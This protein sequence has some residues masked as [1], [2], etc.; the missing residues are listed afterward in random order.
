MAEN[1]K[2]SHFRNGDRIPEAR[3]SEEWVRSA[4]GGKPAWCIIQNDPENGKKYG[5]LYNW[6]A[7]N[8]PRGLAPKGFHIASDDE[9]TQLTNFLGGGMIAALK[10]RSSGFADNVNETN[11]N[12]FEGLPGGNRSNNGAFFGLD[13]FGYWW[14]STEFN[15][16]DAWIRLLNYVLC[17]IKSPVYNK[18]F[19]LSVR[20]IRD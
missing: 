14:S 13:S 10:M 16:S 1:L 7:V 12:R 2:V 8:D 11:Q 3:S 19:G 6:F 4:E 18:S 20:C 17:D 5:K 15:E 9:W